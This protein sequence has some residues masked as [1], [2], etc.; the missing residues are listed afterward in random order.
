MSCAQYWRKPF[1]ERMGKVS[2]VVKNVYRHIP[3][4]VWDEA[5]K[6]FLYGFGLR[7]EVAVK[8]IADA[9]LKFKY[10]DSSPSKAK[11]E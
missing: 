8:A 1:S 3:Q 7:Y 4:D 11:G 9:M 10:G 2:G 6:A 5:E